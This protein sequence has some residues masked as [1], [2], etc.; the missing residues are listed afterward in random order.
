MP[1]GILQSFASIL[2]ALSIIGLILDIAGAVIVLGPELPGVAWSVTRL[3]RRRLHRL[4]DKVEKGKSI[5]TTNRGFEF[6]QTAVGQFHRE[7]NTSRPDHPD[8]RDDLD[9]YYNFQIVEPEAERIALKEQG[10]GRAIGTNRG[11]LREAA[12]N[13]TASA[14]LF[15]R[16]GAF[17]LVAGFFFQLVAEI[18]VLNAVVGFSIFLLGSA[19]LVAIGYRY[20]SP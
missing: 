12:D 7:G 1:S 10:T 6:L 17:A 14:E 13:F 18:A 16:N 3:E 15:Y 11:D 4:L 8:N 20:A 2:P 9:L 19:V 5:D